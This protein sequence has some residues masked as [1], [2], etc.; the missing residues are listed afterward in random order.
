MYIKLLESNSQ[1]EAKINKALAEEVNKKIR[2]SGVNIQRQV[3]PFVSSAIMKQPEV[4]S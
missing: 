2:K 4:Q 1:I 3:I